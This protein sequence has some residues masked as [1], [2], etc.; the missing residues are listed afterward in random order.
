MASATHASTPRDLDTAHVT[1]SRDDDVTL[2]AAEMEAMGGF[3]FVRFTVGDM[4]GAGR[5]KAVP[6]C[7]VA[8]I[9]RR[10]VDLFAG[11]QQD[12]DPSVFLGCFWI[13][14]KC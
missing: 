14:S 13:K 7:H 10:G 3:D 8:E 6:R 2:S 1:T 11:M 5:C 4:H 12:T 9:A